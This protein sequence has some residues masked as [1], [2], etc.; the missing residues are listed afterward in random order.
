MNVLALDPAR[1]TGFCY[2][3]TPAQLTF[4]VWNLGSGPRR[5]INLGEEINRAL[6]RFPACEVIAYERAASGANN[7]KVFESHCQLATI[8]QQ[9][10]DQRGLK[11]WPF[12]IQQWK[13]IGLGSG[14]G[15]AK[16]DRYKELVKIRLGIV[17]STVD[18]AAAVG[19]W[20]AAQQ[21][22]PVSKKKAAKQLK[23]VL[24]KRQTR[25][26]K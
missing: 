7:F 22:P 9:V 2:G 3:P 17:T 18:E 5:L 25:L 8:I 10:A 23:K 1:L 16:P 24:A 11:C 4:G 20:F 21:G 26:F 15:H 19:V 12:L 14:A 6:D 13:A